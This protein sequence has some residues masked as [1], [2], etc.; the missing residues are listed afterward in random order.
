MCFIITLAHGHPQLGGGK[1]GDRPSPSWKHKMTISIWGGL[2]TLLWGSFSPYEGP[3][4]SFWG[5][6]FLLLHCFGGYFLHVRDYFSPYVE[7]FS[8]M[9]SLTKIAVSA[10]GLA[11]TVVASV[12]PSGNLREIARLNLLIDFRAHFHIMLRKPMK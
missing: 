7:S 8:G 4:F 1:V 10:H 3:L 12:V 2:F 11:A 9:S 6:L 5:A